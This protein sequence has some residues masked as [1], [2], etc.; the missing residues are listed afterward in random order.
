MEHLVGQRLGQYDV[1]EIIGKGG[2]A[3]V[4]RARQDTVKRDVAVKVIMSGLAHSPDSLKRF[5]REAETVASLSHPHILRIFDYG[6]HGDLVYLVMELLR[7]GSLADLIR[8]GPLPPE[9]ASRMLDQIA[10]ALDY[11]HKQGIIH[12]DFKP[13]NVLLDSEGNAYLTDFGIAKILGEMTVLTQ[14]GAAMGTPL[15]MPPEQ[16]KGMSL[17]ARADIYAL[18]V[19]LFEMLTGKLPFESD[20]PYGM[21]YKHLNEAPPSIRD[22]RADLPPGIDQVLLKAMAKDPDQRFVSAGELATA[23]KRALASSTQMQV[24][25]MPPRPDDLKTIPELQSSRPPAQPPTRP[26]VPTM[27][28]PQRR[29][30][31]FLGIGATVI[32]I[33]LIG[34]FL[35]ISR[36]QESSALA[37]TGT[38]LGQL[39]AGQAES[40]TSVAMVATLT[41][42]STTP[43][44]SQASL[45]TESPTQPPTQ[46][47][48]QPPTATLTPTVPTATQSPAPTE[49][50]SPTLTLIPTATAS[51]TATLTLAPTA[52][53]T[54]SPTLTFTPL[55]SETPVPTDTDTPIPPTET[56]TP[57]RS[58]SRLPPPPD[59][60]STI[61]PDSVRLGEF[62]VEWYCN[63]R[64]YG[65]TL[66]NNN[67][68]W[69]CTRS[70]TDRTVVFVLR[71]QDLDTICRHTYHSGAFAIRDQRK[72]IPAHNWSCYEYRDETGVANDGLGSP[73]ASITCPGALPSRL[74]VGGRGRVTPGLPNRLR[75]R[76][77]TT[78]SY[79]GQ[80][81]PGDI[82][83]VLEGPVCAQDKA[84]WRVRYNGIEGWTPEGDANTYWVEPLR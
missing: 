22:V 18:G 67:R 74:V 52:T 16:W 25:P 9:A 15:Y 59:E 84:W 81:M 4:Y 13:Q 14:S 32:A 37:A 80:M 11:A 12:R 29:S 46:L 56:R 66:V 62:Q 53:E 3:A 26:T 64:G 8:K 36:V 35:V 61:P 23:F 45:P 19:T 20:T 58:S 55:P 54:A 41:A 77:S 63:D 2:M 5:Q 48:T 69:A 30:P 7:G 78:G 10:S 21:M 44:P 65:T 38:A 76:P 75:S 1:L 47:P 70:A 33:V 49:T 17:D 31:A 27:P 71:V 68:D 34:A 43:T 83:F 51:L 40:A 60:R 28:T 24:Q 6:Q 50:A 79:L 42:T 72:P 73:S 39:L 82:F 57:R